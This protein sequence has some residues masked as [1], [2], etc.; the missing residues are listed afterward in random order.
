MR[1]DT[2]GGFHIGIIENEVVGPKVWVVKIADSHEYHI[3]GGYAQPGMENC[4]CGEKV[5]IKEAIDPC[6]IA[7]RNGI[8]TL[9]QW[10]NTC[11]YWLTYESLDQM[12]LWAALEY[13]NGSGMREHICKR[14]QRKHRDLLLSEPPNS[15]SVVPISEIAS[16][17]QPIRHIKRRP[18]SWEPKMVA[19]FNSE[20]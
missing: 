8:Q 10:C 13:G 4:F 17:S 7:G 2:E 16:S 3:T 6:D 19:K 18:L 15:F 12:I 1:N 20:E 11:I 14:L 5:T 9:D